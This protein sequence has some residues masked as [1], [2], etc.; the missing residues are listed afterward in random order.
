M[1]RSRILTALLITL[2]SFLVAII[3]LYSYSK[4]SLLYQTAFVYET[5]YEHIP[6][7][8]PFSMLP[9]LLA[10]GTGLW[11]GAIDT[12]FRRLQP[13]LS[14]TEAPTSLQH[15]AKLTYSS[16]YWLW[17]ALKAASNKHWLLCLVT[18][19]TSLLQVCMS[20]YVLVAITMFGQR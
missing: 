19:G 20:F 1:L 4:R 13:Y 8:T 12:T 10:V 14:M 16:S 15:G 5:S 7:L 17:A 11:W 6:S 9:T 2:T 18:L 3:V